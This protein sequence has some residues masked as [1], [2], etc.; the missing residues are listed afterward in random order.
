MGNRKNEI[1]QRVASSFCGRYKD[2]H[3]FLL[4]RGW[5]VYTCDNRQK[6]SKFL[7][8]WATVFLFSWNFAFLWFEHKGVIC[9]L[10][11]W[12]LR[13]EHKVSFGHGQMAGWFAMN[14]L[15]YCIGSIKQIT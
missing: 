2:L 11:S 13:F 8:E 12:W 1:I 14:P 7:H 9:F 6:A 5:V 3:S 15:L 4:E 10:V